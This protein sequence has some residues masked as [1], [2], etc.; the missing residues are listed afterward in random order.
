MKQPSFY[1][2]A[3]EQIAHV[4][5]VAQAAAQQKAPELAQAKSAED[6]NTEEREIKQRLEELQDDRGQAFQQALSELRIV[7][8]AQRIKHLEELRR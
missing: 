1:D 6:L 2:P 5:L 4:E 8:E 3:I 7:E